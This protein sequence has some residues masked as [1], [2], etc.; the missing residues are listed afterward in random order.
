[1]WCDWILLR[2]EAMIRVMM[3]VMGLSLPAAWRTHMC[4][5]ICDVTM[6]CCYKT[7]W[8]VW[9]YSFL[10]THWYVWNYMWCDSAMLLHDALMCAIL[11]FPNDALICALHCLMWLSLVATWR[12]DMCDTVCDV[13]KSS[14]YMMQRYAWYFSSI[15][16]HWYVR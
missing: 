6:S 8:S 1:M 3:Y 7:H 14:C 5:T 13:T 10:M 12:T 9:F 15:M 11:F 2:L 4:D 16:T